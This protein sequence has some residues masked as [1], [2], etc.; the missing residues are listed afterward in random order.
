MNFV[1]P[2]NPVAASRPRV[3]RWGTY[4]AEPYKSWKDE[5]KD[6]FPDYIPETFKIIDYPVRVDIVA[7]MTP[8]GKSKLIVPKQDVDNLA[9][10]ALDACNR[11][12][13]TDDSLIQKLTIEKRWADGGGHI[14]MEVTAWK[15][16]PWYIR[17]LT[18][19]GFPTEHGK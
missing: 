12:V 4:Y 3:T 9:K 10:A 14:D 5:A 1:F 19:L 2:K 17:L 13:W 6:E 18:K 8:P 11:L 7:H 16:E 15:P